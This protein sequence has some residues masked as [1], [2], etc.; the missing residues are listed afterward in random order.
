MTLARRIARAAHRVFDTPLSAD[1]MQRYRV[2]LEDYLTCAVAGLERPEI[3]MARALAHQGAVRWPGDTVGYEPASAAL[4]GGTAGALLQLHDVYTPG[5]IHPSSPIIPAAA[6]AWEAANRPTDRLIPA[7]AAGYEVAC[8]LSAQTYPAQQLAG[9][10][11][12]A[13]WGALGAATAAALVDGLDED[14]TM[15][16]LANATMLCPL[17]AFKSLRD[18][19]NSAALHSGLAARA[20][21]EA[22]QLA[23]GGWTAGDRVLSSDDTLPGWLKMLDMNEAAV[24]PET[25][26]GGAVEDVVWKFFPACF[27]SHVAIE[28]AL[29]VANRVNPSDVSSVML[30]VPTPALVLTGVG[31]ASDADLYDQLMSLRWAVA[32]TLVDGAFGVGSLERLA[33]PDLDAL[34]G[35]ITVRAERGFDELLPDTVS[36]RIVVRSIDG[37][38][39]DHLR[40]RP[41]LGKGLGKVG[42][43]QA[44]DEKRFGEKWSQLIALAPARASSLTDWL[45]AL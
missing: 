33:D 38:T 28:A 2:C 16:A 37:E 23:Q 26:D 10:T 27:A 21:V 9:T 35:K 6:A 7:I 30:D 8:R 12:T 29:A 13:T 18:H 11:P 36:A 15:A 4:V 39:A 1:R 17:V 34:I 32:R 20:G 45:G 14:R 25:W 24:S 5:G 31:P 19:A 42:W 41:K 44:I 3:E 22:A 40:Q 43:S